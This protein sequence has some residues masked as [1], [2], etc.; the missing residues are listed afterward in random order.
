MK[1]KLAINLL[2][3]CIKVA[4]PLKTGKKTKQSGPDLVDNDEG[5]PCS[6]S[7]GQCVGD[8]YTESVKSGEGRK[9]QVQ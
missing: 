6:Q 8:E 3:H 7:Q 9:G 5:S 2:P 1:W 4:T